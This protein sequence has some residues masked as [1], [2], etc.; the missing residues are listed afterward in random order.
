M[1]PIQ[2][3]SL[4]EY[5]LW[6]KDVETRYPWLR[7]YIN[8]EFLKYE[9][10]RVGDLSHWY[11]KKFRKEDSNGNLETASFYVIP[12]EISSSWKATIAEYG[13]FNYVG[14]SALS[15]S[16]TIL[17]I[18]LI[19]YTIKQPQ[20]YRLIE[21]TKSKRINLPNRRLNIIEPVVAIQDWHYLN[22][23]YIYVDVPYE[24]KIIGKVIRE[25]LI[26][27]RQI[28]L[29]FQSP[30]ISA[31]RI[32]GFI[33][34][35]SLS[36]IAGHST[37]ARELVKTIQLMVPPEYRTLKP[38]TKAFEGCK[39]QYL[40][41]A[42]FHLAERPYFDNSILSSFYTKQYAR[43]DKELSRRNSFIGEFSIFSTIN[44]AEGNITQIW[45]EL[46][47]NFTATEIT[48]P[49]NID[50]LI[51]ADV[52]LKPLKSV[53][54]EDLWIQIVHSRQYKPRMDLKT[55]NEFIKT[56]NL[57]KEDFD[58]LLADIHKQK[59]SRDYIVRSM[60]Y[61]SSYNLKRL[62]QSFAR[63]EEKENLHLNH[64]KMARD[65]LIDNFKGFI[66][67]PHFSMIKS[68]METGKENARYSVVQ[69]EI[70]NKPHSST[71]EIFEAIKS[72]SLFNDIYDLQCFLDWLRKK[73]Y[74]IMDVNN[75]YM[76]LGR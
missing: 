14:L 24:K 9:Q 18:G 23:D 33:G 37:F 67:H 32:D 11:N 44:P 50:E 22:S 34:G 19:P 2:T 17:L 69:T 43:L 29:S 25:N 56:I 54:N 5:Y 57:L 71:A 15:N 28:S 66:S 4:K 48:L 51:E 27:D 76:W 16:P 20:E 73:G 3:L 75:R 35:I 68:R 53:I 49:Q 1:R 41:G 62:A 10:K 72:T 63:S 55:G 65:L 38:P 36:S 46:M 7:Q 21:I 52:Y 8:C 45:K 31:P 13:S 6:K 61:P 40:R 64:L 26:D 60:L 47:K 70:I 59:K 42:K 12:I 39:F 74:V 30:I 58:T